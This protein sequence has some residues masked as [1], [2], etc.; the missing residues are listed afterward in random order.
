M[1]NARLYQARYSEALQHYRASLKL[2]QEGGDLESQVY[3]WNNIGA[4]NFFQGA[5]GNAWDDYSEAEKLLTEGQGEWGNRARNTTLVNQATLL[6]RVGRL[7]EA[8][9]LY[10]KVVKEEAETIA[11]AQQLANL[12]ALY[13]RL[14][15]P[16]KAIDRYRKALAVFKAQQ[17]ADG[18]LGTRKNLAMV[19]YQELGE[20][21]EARRLLA[22]VRTEALRVGNQREALVAG[23]NLAELEEAAG[24]IPAA[25]S[26]WTRALRE[27]TR[28]R[29]PEQTWP[30]YLGLARLARAEGDRKLALEMAEAAVQSAETVRSGVKPGRQR[31]EFLTD[32]RDLYDLRVELLLEKQEVDDRLIE[33]IEMSRSRAFQEQ[34][35]VA[36]LADLRTRLGDGE[37]LAITWVGRKKMAWVVVDSN[38]ARLVEFDGASPKGSMREW[39]GR[40]FGGKNYR[41]LY[42]VP[43]RWLAGMTWEGD[44]NVRFLPAAGM[45]DTRQSHRRVWPWDRILLAIG[46]GRFS[47]TAAVLAGAALPA[48]ANVASEVKA[49]S[50]SLSGVSTVIMDD[51]ARHDT[52][53][54]IL[55][56]FAIVHIAGHAVAD[57]EDGGRSQIVLYDFP[58]YGREIEEMKLDGV[59]LVVLSGCSTAQGSA[60]PGEGIESLARVFL[61][62]GA[63]AVVATQWPIEDRAARDF[64]TIFYKRLGEGEPIA[65]ALS[66]AKKEMR[67]QSAS[68]ADAFVLW[69]NGN[70]SLQSALPRY[71]LVPGLSVLVAAG[72]CWFLLNKRPGGLPWGARP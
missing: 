65:R 11:D 4:A 70:A 35:T 3:R 68:V 37:V 10:K 42:V 40:A 48:L 20:S 16:Y 50:S 32:K 67:Q 30:A 5:Y 56:N 44:A 26:A 72:I 38:S 6:Q 63:K 41:D 59:Q 1:G 47:D 71:F 66:Q 43:D 45:L 58:L 36:K 69:G 29:M 24:N 54:A 9:L 46:V 17:Y 52:V 49:V 14:G 22:A 57:V 61:R 64:M 23:L 25:K 34:T 8:L 60:M 31:L 28:L 12:G 55:D 13:R 33:A 62:A 53:K 7:Q 27:A 51:Q 21:G 39:T 15:D 18:V 2:A 19:L